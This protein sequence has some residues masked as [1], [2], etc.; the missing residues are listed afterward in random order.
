MGIEGGGELD[1]PVKR[2]P[3]GE[4]DVVAVNDGGTFPVDRGGPLEESDGGQRDVVGWAPN[5]AVHSRETT[6]DEDSFL[7]PFI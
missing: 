5:H 7:D 3:P 6:I 1:A 2:L 4:G